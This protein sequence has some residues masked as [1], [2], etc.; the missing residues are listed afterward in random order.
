MRLRKGKKIESYIPTAS[1]ADIAFL[2]IIFFMITAQFDVDKTHLT[3][4]SSV[5]REEIPKESAVVIAA[6]TGGGELVIKVT[7]GKEQSQ[8]V[9]SV[10][11]VLSFAAQEM[12]RNPTKNFI[13]KADAKVRYGVIDDILDRLRQA[14]VQYIY[15]LS[16]QE[17]K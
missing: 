15:F 13:I 7:S 5:V 9:S 1:M 17:T 6:L 10:D 14:R 12:Q 4:P 2:L 8:P 11:D 16:T 3:L